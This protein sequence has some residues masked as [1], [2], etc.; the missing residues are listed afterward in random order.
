[1]GRPTKELDE[2]YAEIIRKES[3][4][5]SISDMHTKCILKI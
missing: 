2:R 4:K 1:M 3:G 5:M